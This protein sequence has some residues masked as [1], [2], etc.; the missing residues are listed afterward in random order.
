ME[1]ETFLA[2]NASKLNP[3]QIRFMKLLIERNRDS[4]PEVRTEINNFFKVIKNG[5]ASPW[6]A[7]IS[8]I[9]EITP[10]AAK[11]ILNHVLMW[12]HTH[13]PDEAKIN[14]FAELIKTGKWKVDTKQPIMISQSGALIDGR[15]RLMAIIKS[16]KAA[17]MP[18]IFK[19]QVIKTE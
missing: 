10:E 19:I 11:E 16:N 9:I 13:P 8:K 12:P 15:H 4:S 17:K 1:A 3:D 5:F 7:G 14:R 6:L 18:V 2:T